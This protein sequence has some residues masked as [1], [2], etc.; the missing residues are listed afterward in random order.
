LA[1]RIEEIVT[2]AES[3]LFSRVPENLAQSAQRITKEKI[4]P[5]VTG[6]LISKDADNNF[7]NVDLDS[8]EQ[9][10]SREIGGEWLVKQVFQKLCFAN[11]LEL[12][13][14]HKSQ[15][16]TALLLLTVK[17]IHPSSELE[18]QR[19]LNESSAALELYDNIEKVT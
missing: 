8:I 10:E 7:Q 14:L 19:W 2:V 12:I 17:L 3:F 9:T 13:G 11:V 1:D 6:K 18:T 16:D 15:I 4:F 5:S